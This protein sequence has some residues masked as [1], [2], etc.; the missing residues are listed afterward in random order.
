M[1]QRARY[2]EA[3]Q[4]CR[5]SLEL[6]QSSSYSW[7]LLGWILWRGP[8]ANTEAEQAYR[9]AIELDPDEEQAWIDLI[10]LVAMDESRLSEAFNL[11]KEFADQPQCSAGGL[12][13]IAY[14]TAGSDSDEHEMAAERWARRA[15][16][17]DPSN[18]IA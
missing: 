4:A 5:K 14:L 3:E 18:A 11:A 9:K 12:A 15:L 2:D 17:L 6:D 16:E 1:P 7:E 8:G 13:T 10:L